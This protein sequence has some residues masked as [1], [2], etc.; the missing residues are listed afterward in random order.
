MIIM[1]VTRLQAMHSS[2]FKFLFLFHQTSDKLLESGLNTLQSTL[3]LKKEVEVEKVQEDLDI[4]RKQFT[5][6]MEAC[7]AKE[8]ELKKKQM[9]V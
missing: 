7:R 6:R 2:M 5:E 8:E 4:K 9:Q 1:Y 3:L